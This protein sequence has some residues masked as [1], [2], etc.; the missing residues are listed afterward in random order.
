MGTDTLVHFGKNWGRTT[1]AFTDLHVLL[2]EGTLREEQM[3]AQG[4]AIEKLASP[5]ARK[6]QQ[7]YRQ[8]L[9]LCPFLGD[10]LFNIER[11]REDIAHAAKLVSLAISLVL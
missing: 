10:T 7:L 11:T 5:T 9:H 8:L 1:R 6:Q 3:K 2:H 4:V